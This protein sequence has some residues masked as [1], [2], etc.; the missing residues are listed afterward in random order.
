MPTAFGR[1]IPDDQLKEVLNLFSDFKLSPRSAIE[2][3]KI[4]NQLEP[5]PILYYNDFYRC[6][7]CR[8]IYWKGSHYR[9]IENHFENTLTERK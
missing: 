4:I 7:H 1:I 5:K 2:K 6:E 3:E 9:K 8:Q